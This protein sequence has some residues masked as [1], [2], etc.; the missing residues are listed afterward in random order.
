MANFKCCVGGCDSTK[1]TLRLFSFPK[2]ESLRNLWLSFLVPTNPLLIGLSKEQLLR[3]RVCEKHFDKHQFDEEG[4][5]RRYSYPTLFT[6][7]EIA[8]GEPFPPAGTGESKLLNLYFTFVLWI[9]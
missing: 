4:K 1:E 5:R 2:K 6:S 7:K 8:H 9:T 3:K